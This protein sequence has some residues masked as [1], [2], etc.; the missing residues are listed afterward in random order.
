MHQG[1]SVRRFDAREKLPGNILISYA[2]ECSVCCWFAAISTII[3][4]H[5]LKAF[6]SAPCASRGTSSIISNICP[7]SLYIHS[8]RGAHSTGKQLLAGHCGVIWEVWSCS[9]YAS[10][11][12][13]VTVKDRLAH[14]TSSANL[15]MPPPF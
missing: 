15:R 1:L 12:T 8:M 11:C 6:K 9:S 13:M 10:L 2:F 14:A 3:T 4:K 7:S 5:T